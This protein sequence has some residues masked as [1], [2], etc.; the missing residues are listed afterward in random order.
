MKSSPSSHSY[1]PALTLTGLAIILFI[2][3]F[4]ICSAF[5]QATGKSYAL[6]TGD[7]RVD[8]FAISEDETAILLTSSHSPD[9][10]KRDV[11][12]FDLKA[13]QV[14][15]LL[16]GGSVG[17]WTVP[18]P[19]TFAVSTSEGLYLIKED[20]TVGA[21][22][23]INN[24]RGVLQWTHDGNY[25]VFMTDRPK[26]DKNAENYNDMGF[27]AIG[28]LDLDTQKVR[29]FAVKTPAF[30][31]HVLYSG[32]RTEKIYVADDTAETDKQ[33]TINI[34]D[35]KG[36]HLDTRFNMYGINFS[37]TGEYYLPYIFEAGLPFRARYSDSGKTALSFA[38]EGDEEDENPVW[39]PQD[40]NLLLVEHHEKQDLK[41]IV[42]FDVLNVAQ[43]T[44]VKSVPF[45]IAQ[46]TPDGKTLVVFRDGKFV[47]ELIPP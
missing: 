32:D 25:F 43:R 36:K 3:T 47:F 26:V 5:S 12:L 27:T 16:T 40:D 38:N 17:V 22:M 15:K 4:S 45:G 29:Q 28:I 30:R 18:I 9:D 42:R 34:Y 35:V 14:K 44:I 20:G 21:P 1:L 13:G 39:N 6:P 23:V 37:A 46:W 11:F 8:Q 7:Y 33:P 19:R 24:L 31:F 10:G 41:S 2:F